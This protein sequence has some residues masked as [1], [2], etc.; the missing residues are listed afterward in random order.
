LNLPIPEPS[1]FAA[2]LDGKIWELDELTLLAEARGLTSPALRKLFIDLFAQYIHGS[3]ILEVACGIGA[4]GDLLP[5][6]LRSQIIM[7]DFEL[8]FVR[9]TQEK[10]PENEVLQ[11]DIFN[12]PFDEDSLG[13][14]V[15]LAAYDA[16]P[17]TEKALAE[18]YRVLKP[19]G[20]F[21]HVVDLIAYPGAFFASLPEGTLTLPADRFLGVRV[22][23]PGDL[24]RVHPSLQNLVVALHDEYPADGYFILR[25]QLEPIFEKLVEE[26]NRIGRPVTDFRDWFHHRFRKLVTEAGFETLELGRKTTFAVPPPQV[27]RLLF[28]GEVFHYDWGKSEPCTAY[29]SNGENLRCTVHVTVVR[30]PGP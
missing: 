28:P 21:I 13:S 27:S 19:G 15:C 10:F 20:V 4:L 25:G 11:A 6:E 2:T 24:E 1:P 23:E 12:L 3:P 17:N 5:P 26:G 22:L 30:K 16:L 8:D 7:S 29:I 9:A 18:T 14:V